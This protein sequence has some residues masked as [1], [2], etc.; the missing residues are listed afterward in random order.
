[1]STIGNWIAEVFSHPANLSTSQYLG[2]LGIIALKTTVI[3][4]F[5]VVGLRVLGKRQLGQ[6]NIYDLVLVIIIANA[7]QNAMVGDD[8]TVFGGITAATTLLLLNRVFSV[9]LT[10]SRKLEHLMVGE[11]VI[12]VHDGQVVAPRLEHECITHEQIMAALREHGLERLEQ[13]HLA[14]LEVDGTIS[15]ISAD[16]E[17]YRSRR[18]YRALR[19]P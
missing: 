5:L 11:P 8:T 15:V 7:V 17:V 2:V 12:L 1:M 3:Y 14:V 18:H 9:A 13:V 6:M 19:L 16:A 10:R 4:F